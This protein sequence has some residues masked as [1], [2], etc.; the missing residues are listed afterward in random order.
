MKCAIKYVFF[1]DIGKIEC[2]HLCIYTVFVISNSHSRFKYP[3]HQLYDIVILDYVK[4]NSDK[5]LVL[6]V[7]V[8][9]LLLIVYTSTSIQ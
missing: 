9:K 3:S 7:N 8:T 4:Y 6:E 5:H 2:K 1:Q